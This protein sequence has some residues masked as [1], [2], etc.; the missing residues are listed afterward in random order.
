[1]DLD[2]TENPRLAHIAEFIKEQEKMYGPKKTATEILAGLCVHLCHMSVVR[3]VAHLW[4]SGVKRNV[5]K[6]L[7]LLVVLL[8]MLLLLLVAGNGADQ[9]QE[10]VRMVPGLRSS[11]MGTEKTAAIGARTRFMSAHGLMQRRMGLIL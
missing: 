6:M 7:L 10:T 5:Q 2:S 8:V 11:V 9:C 3:Q 4:T 1:M